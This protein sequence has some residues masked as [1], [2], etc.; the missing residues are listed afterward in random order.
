MEKQSLKM[1]QLNCIY[2]VGDIASERG[3]VIGRMVLLIHRYPGSSPQN[4]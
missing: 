2:S 4:L 1:K 3:T